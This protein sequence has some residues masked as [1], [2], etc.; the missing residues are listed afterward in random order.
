VLQPWLVER[1]R[2][3]IGDPAANQV[4]LPVPYPFLGGSGEPDTYDKGDVWVFWSI[5]GGMFLGD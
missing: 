2:A 3:R 1:V 4:Y 5:V